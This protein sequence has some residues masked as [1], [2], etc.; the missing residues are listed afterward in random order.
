VGSGGNKLCLQVS[1]AVVAWVDEG[2]EMSDQKY[3]NKSYGEATV[4]L[5]SGIYTKQDI[6]KILSHLEMVQSALD[7]SMRIKEDA[8]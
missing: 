2:G 5:Q 7:I 1:V 3:E 6:E 4:E 8:K